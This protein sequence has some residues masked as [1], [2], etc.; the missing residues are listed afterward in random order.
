ME[1]ILLN[2]RETAAF[3]GISQTT[4][5]KLTKEGTLPS[6]KLGRSVKWRRETLERR[7]EEMESATA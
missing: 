6:V 1:P 3:L 7:I 5:W 2:V 4:V